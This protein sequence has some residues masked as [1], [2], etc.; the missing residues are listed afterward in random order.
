MNEQLKAKFPKWC[1]EDKQCSTVLTN[2]IDSLLGC[3]IEEKVR[4]NKIN[5]FY[6]FEAMYVQDKDVRLEKL[7]IDLA[8]TE[9]KVFDNHVTRMHHN[10]KFNQQSANINSILNVS[11]SNYFT[12][13]TMSTAIM[14]W[15]FYDLPLPST[16]LG[17]MLLLSIDVG[18][19]GHYDSRFKEVHN[20]YLRLLGY[21]ELID[22]LNNTKKQDYYDLIKKY[23]LYEHIELDENGYLQTKLPLDVL[24]EALELQLEL[25]SQPFTLQT[26]YKNVGRAV[27][28]D[29]IGDLN[30][31]VIS[32]A[33]TGKK[34]YK[35]TMKK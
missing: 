3:T 12:K 28:G 6:N 21:E 8:W 1:F 23:K 5:Y 26:Q 27:Q 10:S 17:K 22:L 2:D 7:G 11:R 18:F 34:Y 15:S 13:Y 24:S 9:G 14:M 20:K 29:E 30:K 32:F 25:P 31:N 4:G 35:F 19:K 16:K 33:L